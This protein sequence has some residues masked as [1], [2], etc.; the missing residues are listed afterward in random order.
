MNW[1]Q[2]RRQSIRRITPVLLTVIC[3][4]PTAAAPDYGREAFV[5]E[6]SRT[7]WRFENDGTGTKRSETRVRIQSDAGIQTWG[8]LVLGYNAANER[9]DIVSV[10][11]TKPDGTAV[12]A[13]ASAVQD[14]SSSVERI[15]PVY[16]DWRE[17]H[18]TVPG[19]G[20]ATSSSTPR[21]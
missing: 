16:T 7:A 2:S 15:A 11:V 21:R 9:L 3:A 17:K 1:P 20:Q 12:T 10:R 14:L 6:R 13:S 19:S 8:Q 5:V 4:V 18:V